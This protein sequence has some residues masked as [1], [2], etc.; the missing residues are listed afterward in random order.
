MKK[1]AWVTAVGNLVRGIA[2]LFLLSLGILTEIA[3][4]ATKKL[5]ET[6]AELRGEDV[7]VEEKP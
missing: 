5:D 2:D 3:R 4:V 1:Q 6:V 7:V